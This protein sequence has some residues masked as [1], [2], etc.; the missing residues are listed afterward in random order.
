M[1]K[2]GK[3]QQNSEWYRIWNS[4]FYSS[5]FCLFCCSFFRTRE[6]QFGIHF[7]FMLRTNT[8]FS[9]FVLFFTSKT[10]LRQK[11]PLPRHDL[12]AILNL[13]KTKVEKKEQL[14]L[15]LY[16]VACG[17]CSRIH[18]VCTPHTDGKLKKKNN[19][20][21]FSFSFSWILI[22]ISFLLDFYFRRN[23]AQ[24]EFQL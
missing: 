24:I 17:I 8:H 15:N 12:R 14:K 22:G 19:S 10:G 18:P 16:L 4:F 2:K 1:K 3:P 23:F 13:F 9:N 20:E 21:S 11:T 7:R 5:F 6:I